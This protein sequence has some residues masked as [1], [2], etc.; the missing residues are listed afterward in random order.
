[1]NFS[2]I[3]RGVISDNN[4]P[5]KRGRI[6]AYVPAI[7]EH[8]LTWAEPCFPFNGSSKPDQYAIPP[9]GTKVWIE[10]EQDD[11]DRPIWVGIFF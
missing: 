2:G 7:S 10:F 6:K 1:M 4:D 3:F 5:L 11:P 8:D 9:V